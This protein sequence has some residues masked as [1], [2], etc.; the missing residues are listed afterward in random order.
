MGLGRNDEL[1]RGFDLSSKRRSSWEKILAQILLWKNARQWGAAV[2]NC[3]SLPS[4]WKNYSTAFG[5]NHCP[6]GLRALLD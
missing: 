6:Y 5:W 1:E 2:P 3:A 4:T